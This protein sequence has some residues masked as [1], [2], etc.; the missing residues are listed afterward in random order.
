VSTLR[1]L[2][3]D[4]ENQ[5]CSKKVLE[6]PLGMRQ[7]AGAPTEESEIDNFLSSRKKAIYINIAIL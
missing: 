4:N 3:N 7:H 2:R 5:E 1:T 6:Q